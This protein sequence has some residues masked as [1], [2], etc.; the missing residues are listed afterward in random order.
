MQL[1]GFTEAENLLSKYNIPVSRT[2]FVSNKKDAIKSAKKLEYPVYLKIYGKNILHRTELGGVKEV[3][4]QND[5]EK[6]FSSMQKIKG[7]DGILVQKKAEGKALIVGMKKD[8]QF[9]PVIIV[10]VGGIFAEAINDF[11]LRIAPVSKQEAKKMLEELKGFVYLSG[12]R[13]KKPI[14]IN[15]V[16]ELICNV[17]KLAQKEESIAEITLNPVIANEKQALV[18]DHKILI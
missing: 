13:D 1:I 17:S 14:N 9:G 6:T 2:D 11:V 4:S 3:L 5:L 18:V 10:G 7:V 12:K 16:A 8:A 15:A